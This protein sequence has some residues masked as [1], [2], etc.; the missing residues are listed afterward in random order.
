M[1]TT[2][3]FS[4]TTLYTSDVQTNWHHIINNDVDRLNNSLLKLAAL[5]D[6]DVTGLK[7]GSVLLYNHSTGKWEP[8]ATI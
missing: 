3:K 2:T 1:G 4:F 8:K 6:V 5:N 7:V